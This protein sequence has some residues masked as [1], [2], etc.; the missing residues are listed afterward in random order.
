MKMEGGEISD[1]GVFVECYELLTQS[2]YFQYPFKSSL[3]NIFVS[4]ITCDAKET[5]S[6]KVDEIK[7]KFMATK[8]ERDED[9]KYVFVPIMHTEV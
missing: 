4:D 3:L 9:N 7:C 5:I 6:V 8:A 2:F 1:S